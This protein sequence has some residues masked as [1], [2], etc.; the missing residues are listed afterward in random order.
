MIFYPSQHDLPKLV[1]CY[2][3]CFAGSLTTQLGDQFLSKIIEW[4]IVTDEAFLFCWKDG[5]KYLGFCGGKIGIGSSTAMLQYAFKAAFLSILGR[6]WIIF[7]PS[8]FSKWRF[9]ISN[10]KKKFFKKNIN[11]K[12]SKKTKKSIGL[13][14]IGV[15]S[16]GRG[17]GI[18]NDLMTEFDNKVINLGYEKAHLSAKKSNTLGINL[19]LRH[20]WE[21]KG[22]SG[23]KS[24]SLIK[25][26]NKKK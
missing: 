4:Y 7:N 10:I 24:I 15:L 25:N 13:I 1:K 21:I 8:V 11:N 23:D 12:S 2:K 19:Y 6:P 26:Y 17:K 16:E 20:G 5:E 14:T 22:P 3:S 18:G 9:I